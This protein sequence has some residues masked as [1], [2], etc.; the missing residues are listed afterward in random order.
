MLKILKLK[1][2]YLYSDATQYKNAID[3]FIIK[4]NLCF[5]SM[6]MTF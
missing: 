4:K 6:Q 3:E 2:V 5:L 1:K